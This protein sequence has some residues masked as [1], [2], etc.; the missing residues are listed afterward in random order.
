MMQPQPRFRAIRTMGAACAVATLLLAAPPSAA[1]SGDERIVI[2]GERLPAPAAR[3]RAEAFI[4]GTGVASGNTPAARWVDP[5]C[6]RVLGL[7]EAGTRVAEARIRAV[8]AQAG[9]PLAPAPCDSNIV[10]SFTNDGAALVRE[11]ERRS[12]GRLNQVPLSARDALLNGSA[13]I[14][15]W[16]TAETRGRHNEGSQRV[17]SSA[18]QFTPVNDGAGAGANFGTEVPT[19][20]HYGDSIVSTLMTRALVSAGVVIDQNRVM[21]MRLRA[22]ADYAA[23]VALAEIRSQGFSGQGSVLNL[24]DSAGATAGMTAQDMAFLSA[25]YRMPLDREA[26]RH[27]AHL[28]GEMVATTR[29]DIA[30]VN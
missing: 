11:I 8:A 6:P 21:G 15:W 20:V 16:Y 13:P 30:S 23:L 9:V 14:R 27:R 25:L 12:P 22:L 7:N 1:Q 17:A 2:E 24:F 3:A 29:G 19:A 28:V 10:V 18:G 4:E 26:R 5:V